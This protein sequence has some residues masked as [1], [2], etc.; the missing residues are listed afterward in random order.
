[1][2]CSREG[3]GVNLIIDV[4]LSSTAFSLPSLRVM[5]DLSLV[6]GTVAQK[7]PRIANTMSFSNGGNGLY[8]TNPNQV[9]KFSVN[10]EA[11]KLLNESCGCLYEVSPTISSLSFCF[12]LQSFSLSLFLSLSLSLSLSRS[13][14]LSMLSSFLFFLSLTTSFYFYL[15]SVSRSLSSSVFLYASLTLLFSLLFLPWSLSIFPFFPPPLLYV[16][17]TFPFSLFSLSYFSSFYLYHS[18]SL[19]LSY[20]VSLHLSISF[21]PYLF[22]PY[23]SLFLFLS[24]KDLPIHFINTAI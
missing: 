3:M 13:L 11:V 12:H 2:F 4:N 23:R 20:V 9:Q 22:S 8:F 15:L 10:T 24:I 5:L 16:S 14:S 6:M 21:P 7:S 18:F 19:A 1:M 17:L